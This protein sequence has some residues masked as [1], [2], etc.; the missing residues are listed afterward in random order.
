MNDKILRCDV[1]VGPI[2]ILEKE[3]ETVFTVPLTGKTDDGEFK[4]SVKSTCR[5]FLEEHGIGEVGNR[6]SVELSATNMSLTDY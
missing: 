6:L 5:G 1:V 4:L 3:D 2:H